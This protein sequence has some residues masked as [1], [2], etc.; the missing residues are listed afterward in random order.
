MVGGAPGLGGGP[1]QPPTIRESEATVAA[2]PVFVMMYSTSNACPLTT[3]MPFGLTSCI[4]IS[5]F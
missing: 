1:A 4:E 5:L 3:L 2:V